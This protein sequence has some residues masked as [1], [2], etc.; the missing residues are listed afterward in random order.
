MKKLDVLNIKGDKVRDYSLNKEVFGIVPNDAVLYDAIK[1]TQSSFRQG[2]SDTKLRSEVR[3]GGRKPW[4][5]KGTGRARQGSIRS[6]QWVGGGVVFGP[7][8]RSY[9]IRMNKKESRLAFKSALSYKAL[10]NELIVIENFNLE[11]AKTKD[12]LAILKTLNANKN[13]LIVV[14]ELSDNLILATRNITNV[15]LLQ[16]TEVGTLD[17]VKADALIITEDALK[18]IE[19]VLA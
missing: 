17:V 1:K 5:Q 7:H 8:P 3:G 18:S 2:T 12:M 15:V 19:E 10:N 6:P 4:K 13:I 14:N 16:T 11:T 9:S